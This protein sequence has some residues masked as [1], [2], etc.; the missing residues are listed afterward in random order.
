MIG[1]RCYPITEAGCGPK[2]LPHNRCPLNS[3]SESS[4]AFRENYNFPDLEYEARHYHDSPGA[5]TCRFVSCPQSSGRCDLES[6]NIPSVLCPLRFLSSEW[7]NI[8]LAHDLCGSTTA[9]GCNQTSGTGSKDAAVGRSQGFRRLSKRSGADPG[10]NRT[11]R[12]LDRRRRT[13]RE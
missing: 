3:S 11:D 6:R 1:V 8:V 12:G 4:A 13:Q 5:G 10:R 9:S 7:G 2:K